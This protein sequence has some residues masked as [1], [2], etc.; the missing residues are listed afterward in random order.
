MDSSISILGVLLAT[1][2]AFIVG[3][4]WYSP[5]VFLRQW[6]A[7]TG[8]DDAHM[9]KVFGSSMAYM[10]VGSLLTAYVLAHFVN[11]TMYA[12][13]SSAMTA[14]LVTPFWLWLG[15]SLTTIVANGALDPRSPKL[16]LIQAG[17]RLATLM[18]MGLIIGFFK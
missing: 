14:G 6:Q 1:V 12:T 8:G 16:M 2:S 9:K 7:I 4:I 5:S 13:G 17:N 3:G 15:I 11:F 18:L 10:F